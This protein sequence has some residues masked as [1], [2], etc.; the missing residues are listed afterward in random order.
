MSTPDTRVDPSH[1]PPG[2]EK[3]SR[4]PLRGMLRLPWRRLDQPLEPGLLTICFCV[5]ATQSAWG[6]VVPVLPALARSM[7][8][9]ATELGLIVTAFGVGR[10]LVNIPAGWLGE[11]VDGRRLLV[12]GMAIVVLTQILTAFAPGLGSMLILRLIAGV[13]GGIALTAGMTLVSLMAH[14]HRRGQV[15]SVLQGVQLA[16]G[17]LGPAAGGLIA[18]AFGDRAPFLACGLFAVLCLVFGRRRLFAIDQGDL[19]PTSAKTHPGTTAERPDLIRGPR[20]LAVYAIAFSVFLHR[21]GGVQSLIPL[22]GYTVVGISVG[23]MGALLGLVTG[24]NFLLL[25]ITS[26]LS[27]RVGRKR[28]IVPGILAAGLTMPIFAISH[29]VLAFVSATIMAGVSVAV[30][31]PTPAA[32]IADITPSAYRGR[33]IGIYR[34][35]GDLAAVVGPVGLGAVTDHAGYQAAVLIIGLV[36]ISAALF[37]WVV[38]PETVRH[39]VT[40]RPLSRP[41]RRPG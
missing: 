32:Y 36:L 5:A 14:D 26:G 3:G 13:G 15:L 12:S 19:R 33:A 17:G 24:L 11:R 29:S 27:D 28:V 34:S 8:A 38:A 1:F 22:I 6:I 10:L 39:P 37:F 41:P 25:G 21:F 40:G 31:G 20:F 4:P 7:Q 18:S 30:S 9:S 23:K 35:C 2:L 16:A